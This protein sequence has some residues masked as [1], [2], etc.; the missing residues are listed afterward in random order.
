M[1]LPEAIGEEGE[2]APVVDEVLGEGLDARRKAHLV[3][4]VPEALEQPGGVEHGDARLVVGAYV[5]GGVEQEA[6]AQ[7]PAGRALDEADRRQLRVAVGALGGGVEVRRVAHAARQDALADDSDRHLAGGLRHGQPSERWLERRTG[8]SK[9]RGSQ[10]APPSLP[11]ARGTTPDCDEGRGAAG[12]SS[13]RVLGAPR[14]S[15]RRGSGRLGRRVEAHLRERALAEH[16]EAL[17]EKLPGD[18]VVRSGWPDV[19]ERKRS[20]AR[21]EAAQSDRVL[22]EGG[23]AG[24]RARARLRRGFGGARERLEGDRVQNGRH[25]TCPRDCRIDDLPGLE[26]T[27]ADASREFDRIVVGERVVAES[28]NDRCHVYVHKPPSRVRPATNHLADGV[29]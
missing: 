27:D 20:V 22:E 15:R 17:R 29:E 24:E 21:G 28:M 25:A 6:H 16:D 13:R 1:D 10:R 3:D 18:R 26:L 9:R 4:A 23:H 19:G 7:P 2:H 8:R 14:V 5:A 12:R 11:W